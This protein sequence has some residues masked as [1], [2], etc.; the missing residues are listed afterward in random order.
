[1][2]DFPGDDLYLLGVREDSRFLEFLFEV[3]FWDLVRGA[4]PREFLFEQFGLLVGIREVHEDPPLGVAESGVLEVLFEYI[5]S[6]ERDIV[7]IFGLVSFDGES[8]PFLDKLLLFFALE[9]LFYFIRDDLN[10]HGIREFLAADQNFLYF[11]RQ[12]EIRVLDVWQRKG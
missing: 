3:R 4:E 2:E 6:G 12:R 1:M 10:V 11:F 8:F 5:F 9:V 7:I